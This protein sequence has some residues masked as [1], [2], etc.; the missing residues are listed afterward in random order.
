MTDSR[1][2]INHLLGV[3]GFAIFI[4]IIF[5]VFVAISDST[6][7][8]NAILTLEKFT[9]DINEAQ[10]GQREITL[11]LPSIV[12]SIE[13]VSANSGK[14]KICLMQTCV[15]QCMESP[16]YIYVTFNGK[17]NPRCVEKELCCNVQFTDKTLLGTTTS[18]EIGGKLSYT[19]Q[20]TYDASSKTFNSVVINS[21]GKD[22]GATLDDYRR[23][24]FG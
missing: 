2:L 4:V 13:I 11:E 23:S 14:G 21:K 3:I 12:K 22:W 17:N 6:A 24:V 15:H 20:V 8:G 18:N 9:T 10:N 19:M 7:I 5:V 16:Y 1:E